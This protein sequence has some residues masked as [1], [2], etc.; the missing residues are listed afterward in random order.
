MTFTQQLPTN[1]EQYVMNNKGTLYHL[2]DY[3]G[4]EEPVP[5]RCGIKFDPDARIP[6]NAPQVRTD[7]LCKRCARS[8]QLMGNKYQWALLFVIAG[9]LTV[10]AIGLYL[11]RLTWAGV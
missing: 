11:N 4:G 2:L 6:I 3:Y 8:L 1:P 10:I 7:L 5:T 9:Y